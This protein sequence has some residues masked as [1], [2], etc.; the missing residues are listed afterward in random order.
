MANMELKRQH[1]RK[2]R[3][4]RRRK[5]EQREAGEA[6]SRSCS[7]LRYDESYQAF[8]KKVEDVELGDVKLLLALD[9]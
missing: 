9:R 1:R 3:Q 2:V 4:D 8:L 5:R 7:A 6:V